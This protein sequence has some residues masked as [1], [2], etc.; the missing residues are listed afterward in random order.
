M[1]LIFSL[2]FHVGS[3]RKTSGSAVNI[4]PESDPSRHFL[5][6]RLASSHHPRSPGPSQPH[7]PLSSL[8]LQTPLIQQPV[9]FI[10]YQPALASH[11]RVSAQPSEQRPRRMRSGP[12]RAPTSSPSTPAALLP[13]QPGWLLRCGGTDSDCLPRVFALGSPRPGKPFPH[14]PTGRVAS[15]PSKLSSEVSSEEPL[16]KHHLQ[17]HTPH[18]WCSLPCFIFLHRSHDSLSHYKYVNL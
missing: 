11:L 18:L 2:M 6:S 8:G 17:N 3:L 15:F 1:N 16:I 13:P 14:V 5:C 12:S 9:W 10:H 7:P 4:C